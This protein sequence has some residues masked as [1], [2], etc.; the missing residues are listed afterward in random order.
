M[1]K[2]I[3]EEGWNN[4]KNPANELSARYS[5]YNSPGPGSNSAKRV[6]W[7]KQLNQVEADAITMQK[8]FGT[9]EPI[10]KQF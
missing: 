7:S 10:K 3:I 6:A 5:E 9:W 2:H 1:G 8:V 4:W